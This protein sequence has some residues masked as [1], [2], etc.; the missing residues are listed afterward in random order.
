MDSLHAHRRQRHERTMKSSRLTLQNPSSSQPG[1]DSD[2][3]STRLAL[4]SCLERLEH[5]KRVNRLDPRVH[6]EIQEIH[7]LFMD[8]LDNYQSDVMMADSGGYGGTVVPQAGIAIPP[9]VSSHDSGFVP[10]PAPYRTSFGVMGSLS[11]GRGALQ[12]LLPHSVRSSTD[13]RP[14][15]QPSLTQ[16][17]HSMNS[18]AFSGF[19]DPCITESLTEGVNPRFGQ[20]FQDLSLRDTSDPVHKPT[21]LPFQGIY[22]EHVAPSSSARPDE[23]LSV[24]VVQVSQVKD[25]VKCTWHG[26]AVLV[27]KDNLTRHVEEVHEGKIK[28]VCAGCG[29]KFKRQYQMNEHV[30]RFKCGRS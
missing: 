24:P 16:P 7:S 26:C 25:K 13:Y 20:L 3:H 19:R 22:Y 28:V 17:Q 8:L 4:Q 23:R 14:A 29:R 18:E 1:Q 2:Q 5:L 30:L 12:G 15:A 21:A 11:E 10:Q 27:N 6:A 9:F